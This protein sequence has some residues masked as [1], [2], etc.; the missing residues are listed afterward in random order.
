MKTIM[1]DDWIDQYQ[2]IENPIDK[3]AGYEGCMFETYGEENEFVLNNLNRNTVWTL[4]TGDDE[5]SWVIPGYHIVNRLGYFI[6]TKPWESTDIEVNNNEM[7]TVG[8]AKYACIEFIE[9]KL[10]IPV[11]EFEDE[12][13]DY[14]ANKF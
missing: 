12:I 5:D 8:A 10:N 1:Y 2:P 7:C 6:T 4:I 13:H 3:D 14:F 9:N 11:E